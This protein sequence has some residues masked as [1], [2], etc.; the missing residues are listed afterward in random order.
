MISVQIVIAE[1]LGRLCSAL[2]CRTLPA[3]G[4]LWSFVCNHQAV[5]GVEC[6][7]RRGVMVYVW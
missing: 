1:E 5:L 7:C 3:S 2:Y 4:Y 6:G